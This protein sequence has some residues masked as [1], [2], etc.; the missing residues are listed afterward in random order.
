MAFSGYAKTIK[1]RE[2][3]IMKSLNDIGVQIEPK[4]LK[5]I[6]RALEYFQSLKEFSAT[7]DSLSAD[8]DW[9]GAREVLGI[10]NNEPS[11]LSKRSREFAYNDLPYGST[12]HSF[13]L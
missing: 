6:Q 3:R 9:I 2:D 13:I 8:W 7:P 1:R 5:P 10:L 11:L 4:E 12:R